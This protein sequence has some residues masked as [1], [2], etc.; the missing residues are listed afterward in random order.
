MIDLVISCMASSK[1]P[2]GVAFQNPTK[3]L[4]WMPSTPT[5]GHPS[6]TPD[7]DKL[8]APPYRKGRL[9]P[10][11]VAQ[12]SK[13]IGAGWNDIGRICALGFSA[14][15]NNGL[16]E[17]LRNEED[18]QRIDVLFSVDGLHANLKPGV[19]YSATNWRG[20]Y[21]DWDKEMEPFA[22][23]ATAAA[24]G[25]RLAVFTCSNV[26][27]P[28]GGVVTKTADALNDLLL[29]VETRAPCK[30]LP[31]PTYPAGSFPTTVGAPQPLSKEG[32]RALH[33][34]FYQ[35]NDKQAHITQG[36]KVTDD[37]WRD[38]LQW[39]WGSAPPSS[40]APGA[41]P[42]ASNPPP[43][44]T[45]PPSGGGGPTVPV[46]STT[47]KPKERTPLTTTDKLWIAGGVVVTATTLATCLALASR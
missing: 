11:L 22:D 33:V 31:G 1:I 4:H 29:D 5:S 44:S 10:N 19:A 8:R 17:L 26:A 34:L 21:A 6:W 2:A 46:S 16:R 38:F 25:E 28:A 3:I 12:F 39:V 36:T 15:A 42:G 13:S 45:K 47:T 7:A 35:G 18:R 20:R 40:S 32:F 23:F 30:P 9:L 41:P 37:L 43:P 14:G 24:C 27:S